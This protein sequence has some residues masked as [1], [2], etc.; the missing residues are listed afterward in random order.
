MDHPAKQ[1]GGQSLATS[2]LSIDFLSTVLLIIYAV[3]DV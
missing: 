3:N 1:R 2:G